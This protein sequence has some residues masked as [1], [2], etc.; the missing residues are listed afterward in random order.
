MRPF[1]DL[2]K[3]VIS[4]LQTLG[5]CSGC[6]FLAAFDEYGKTL[7]EFRTDLSETCCALSSGVV[8]RLQGRQ[9]LVLRHNNGALLRR[10][11]SD[12]RIS[13]IGPNLGQIP[14]SLSSVDW[15]FLCTYPGLAEL[16]AHGNEGSVFRG[17]LRPG[18]TAPLLALLSGQESSRTLHQE[19][20]P[21]EK[22]ITE[23]A[24]TLFPKPLPLP[25]FDLTDVADDVE[26]PPYTSIFAPMLGQS[27][28]SD[29]YIEQQLV[30]EA[31]SFFAPHILG[32]AL[33]ELN[34]VDYEYRPG[35]ELLT[36][37]SVFRDP[38]LQTCALT[39]DTLKRQMNCSTLLLDE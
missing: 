14:R 37:L 4:A 24:R 33:R 23:Q 7:L 8:D 5:L 17:R 16:S 20:G 11:L 2:E 12:L 10:K 31:P 1:T 19:D 27:D 22:W 21:L 32:L 35:I 34:L 6:E 28:F 30:S 9:R 13:P 38:I 36:V 39:V 26:M 3:K 25:D 15:L 18:Q 29:P